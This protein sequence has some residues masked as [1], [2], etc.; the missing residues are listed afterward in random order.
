MEKLNA[1]LDWRDLAG[2]TNSEKAKE[3][4]PSRYFRDYNFSIRALFGTDSTHNAVHGSDSIISAE[5]E[6]TLLFGPMAA[7]LNSM[8][9]LPGSAVVSRSPSGDALNKEAET[10]AE[11]AVAP[12]PDSAQE[13]KP[14]TPAA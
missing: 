5:R 12:G 13:A 3:S 4:A 9:S 1:V 10:P 14:A 8:I 6:I 2:P 7:R 11:A